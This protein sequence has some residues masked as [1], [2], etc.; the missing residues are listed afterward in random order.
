MCIVAILSNY[1]LTVFHLYL[2]RPCSARPAS[3]KGKIFVLP[4]WPGGKRGPTARRVGS[5]GREPKPL[6]GRRWISNNSE[7]P[8]AFYICMY[9]FVTIFWV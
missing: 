7:L 4:R 6:P 9:H 1:R 5:R 2:K 8:C 3:S